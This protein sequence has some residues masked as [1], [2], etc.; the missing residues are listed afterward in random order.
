VDAIPAN[1]LLGVNAVKLENAK[2]VLKLSDE[3]KNQLLIIK[4]S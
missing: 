4:I 3:S 2:N 1:V